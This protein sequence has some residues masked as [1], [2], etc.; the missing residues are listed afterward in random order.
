MPAYSFKKRFVPNIRAGLQKPA[1][2][3]EAMAAAVE[4]LDACGGIVEAAHFAIDTV[5]EMPRPKRQTIRAIGKRRHA[6]PGETVQLYCAMRTKQCFKIGDA[7]CT[8]IK[9]I[10]IQVELDLLPIW[11]QGEFIGD[12]PHDFARQDGFEDGHDMREFWLKE[13]GIGRFEGVLIEWEPLP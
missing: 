8:A 2:D 9:R 3:V 5:A 6:R 7:K 10:T 4:L 13:H 11:V 12:V 1:T